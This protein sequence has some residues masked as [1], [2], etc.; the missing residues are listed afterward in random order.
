M[1]RFRDKE[2][3]NKLAL[4]LSTCPTLWELKRAMED[5]LPQFR[6]E[7]CL[8]H[9]KKPYYETT[10]R[11]PQRGGGGCKRHN[12]TSRRSNHRTEQVSMTTVDTQYQSKHLKLKK[13]SQNSWYLCPVTKNLI[14][15]YYP[16]LSCPWYESP[17]CPCVRHI[18]VVCPT[19]LLVTVQIKD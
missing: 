6:K 11:S 5:W 1:T 9:V 13:K 15:L 4:E 2:K 17:I 8:P 14:N 19:H 3:E 16:A 18:L 7:R 10:E 12:Q